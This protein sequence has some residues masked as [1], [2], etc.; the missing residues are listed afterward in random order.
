[1]TEEAQKGIDAA[2]QEAETVPA[3]VPEEIFQY[4]FAEMTPT[5][6]EQLEYLKSTLT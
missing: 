3:P 2:V 6:K 5:L 4:V 1:M